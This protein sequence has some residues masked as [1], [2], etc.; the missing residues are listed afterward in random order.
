MLP[1]EKNISFS[2][3]V[4]L[5]PE[6]KKILYKSFCTSLCLPNNLLMKYM[7]LG[8]KQQNWAWWDKAHRWQNIYQQLTEHWF[9]WIPTRWR[10][11]TR[12]KE[13]GLLLCQTGVEGDRTKCIL[14]LVS[15][16]KLQLEF[17]NPRRYSPKGLMCLADTIWM[18]PFWI[19]SKAH[20]LNH[21]L[22][23]DSLVLAPYSPYSYWTSAWRKKSM[24]VISDYFYKSV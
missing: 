2:V 19:I 1:E 15:C 14:E 12:F 4:T 18:Y 20:A 23:P 21:A 17:K 11:S 10:C 24:Q 22:H 7:F 6:H 3:Y 8:A 9:G 5:G 13:F 16:R